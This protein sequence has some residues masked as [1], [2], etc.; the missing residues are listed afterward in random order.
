MSVV[1]VPALF[2][3]SLRSRGEGLGL[4]PQRAAECLPPSFGRFSLTRSATDIHAPCSRFPAKAL[5]PLAHPLLAARQGFERDVALFT[6]P[7]GE[8]GKLQ[9]FERTCEKKAL[10]KGGESPPLGSPWRLLPPVSPTGR[11]AGAECALHPWK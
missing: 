8:N 5:A 9:M 2:C 7:K 3:A 1:A 4:R 6:L 11:G 10:A